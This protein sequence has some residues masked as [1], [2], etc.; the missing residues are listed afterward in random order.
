MRTLIDTHIL[1]WAALDP[2]KLSP[3]ISIFLM[4]KSNTAV[5]SVISFWEISV[6]YGLGKIDLKNILPEDFPD[7]VRTLGFEII[8]L[9]TSDVASFHNL[10]TTA[11]RDP[12]DRMLIW[13][14][15]R[16]GYTLLSSDSNLGIYK[17][18]GLQLMENKE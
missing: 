4:D 5:V 1:I 15:M 13:Q 2:Q 12:F 3:E 7:I 6:K 14:A 11:H 16:G 8:G 10:P 9:D 17:A 18:F